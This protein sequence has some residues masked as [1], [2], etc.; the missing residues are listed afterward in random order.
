MPT[1]TPGRRPLAFARLDE[2]MP[3]VDRLLAGYTAVGKWTLGQACNHLANALVYTVEGFPGRMPW[4]LRKT[5]GPLIVR[6]MFKTGS[7]REGIKV[8]EEVLPKPGLDDRAEAEAL[9]AAVRLFLAHAGPLAPHPIVD[10][11]SRDDWERFHCIHC[12]H[13]LSFLSPA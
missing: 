2:V 10:R 13:H 4:V 5:I 6:S 12:A 3:D 8:P 9:R 7:I 1:T 11:M